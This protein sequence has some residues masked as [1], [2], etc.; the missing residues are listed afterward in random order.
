MTRPARTALA[1]AAV[2]AAGTPLWVAGCAPAAED[3][4]TPAEP[5][6]GLPKDPRLMHPDVTPAATGPYPKVVADEP[7]H[8]FGVVALGRKSVHTFVVRNQGEAPLLL[9]E[10]I[11]TCKCTAP[12][13]GNDEPIPPGGSTTVTLE[14]DPE[15]AT[16]EFAQRAMIHTN[17]PDDPRLE[18]KITGRVEELLRAVPGDT[19]DFGAVAGREPIKKSLYVV[20]SMTDG[21]EVT[22]T[23]P[24]SE[25]LTVATEK[26]DPANLPEDLTQDPNGAEPTAA[27]R[28]DVTV[29][30]DMAVGRFRERVVVKFDQ[31]DR[32]SHM[33]V[34]VIGTRRGPFAFLP[35]AR[36]DQGD[37]KWLDEALAFDLGTFRAEEGRTGTLM[38][39]V[40]GL[41]EPLELTDVQSTEKYVTLT[42]RPDPS[43]A[44][45]GGRQKVFLDFAVPPGGPPA[46]HK[47][48]GKVTVTAKTNH[49][50]ARE[51]QFYVEMVSYR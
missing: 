46:T 17:D 22:G 6:G 18:L 34:F 41:D 27:V 10:P 12:Q 16:P 3:E 45:D 2:L 30:P 8:D 25:Y 50:E 1:V 13:A 43:F 31:E 37:Q 42:A 48:K 19:L 9:G 29:E 36:G 49:P 15:R 5:L 24:T 47:R 4:G 14:Y 32:Y 20:S 38:M 7:V 33:V 35:V 44:G 26:L 39:F 28:V 23:E 11:T 40:D 51:L 21:F